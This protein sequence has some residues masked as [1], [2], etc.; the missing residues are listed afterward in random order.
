M[1][2][3]ALKVDVDTL[4][5]TLEGVPRLRKLFEDLQ[6]KATFLFSLGPDHTGWALKRIFKP[7]F[8]KKV[9]R[10]SVVEHY[11]L[12]TL[13]YGVLLPAPDIGIKGRS[14]LQSI[15]QAGFEI[16][17][18][19]WDHVVWQDQ[20]RDQ[21]AQWTK[22]QMQKSYVRFQ[23]IFGVAPRTHGAA[24]WQMNQFALEQL[25]L[26]GM[27][28]SSDG[29][30][31]LNLVPYRCQFLSGPSSHI[32]YPTTL[33]TFD[34]LLGV[35]DMNGDDAV[36]HLLALTAN[37]PNDQVFT[38]HA[39]LE[40]QKLLPY[41][42]KLLQGWISQGHACIDMQHLHQSWVATGQTKHLITLPLQF[43]SIPNRSGELL[44]MPFNENQSMSYK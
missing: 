20:V 8:L 4:R 16:G 38:L 27:P 6:I 42:T 30:A 21:D 5:G 11:G 10:T 43:G 28:Y 9:S 12:K 31:P 22:A 39:E 7:G 18:H 1:G 26:W 15:Q 13:S 34:E 25:D 19:T 23:E 29:R 36:N 32:Q 14:I 37:N 44:I 33:P 41:F 17:I 35:N 24:G 2:S 3:I 40:G